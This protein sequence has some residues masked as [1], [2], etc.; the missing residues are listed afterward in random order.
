[1]ISDYLLP[2]TE[3]TGLSL[4]QLLIALAVIVLILIFLFRR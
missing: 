4:T 3:Y 2:I 1:M